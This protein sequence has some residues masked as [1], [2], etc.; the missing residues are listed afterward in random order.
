MSLSEENNFRPE[1]RKTLCN[2][3]H[4]LATGLGSGLSPKAPGTVGSLA[5]IIVYMAFLAHLDWTVQLLIIVVAALLG[6]Y[7]C[8]QTARDWNTHDHGAIVWDEWVAQ[9]LTVIALP[10]N[11]PWLI[12]GFVYFRLFDIWKPW[13]VSWCD[14]HIHGGRGIMLDDILAGVMAWAAMHASM[15]A[16]SQL[17]T[18]LS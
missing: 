16:W 17:L 9:W 10:W 15:Y 7:L 11:S 12:A 5:A 8:G 1:I 2:P 13:P 14:R 6:I 18:V 3:V 4:L